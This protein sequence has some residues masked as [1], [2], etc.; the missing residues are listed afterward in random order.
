[1]KVAFAESVSDP[2]ATTMKQETEPSVHQKGMRV[3]ELDWLRK[4]SNLT[5]RSMSENSHSPMPSRIPS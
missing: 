4:F 1:M 5:V 2:I 3:P